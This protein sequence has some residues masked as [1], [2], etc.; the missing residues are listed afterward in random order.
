MDSVAEGWVPRQSL[1]RGACPD[2]VERPPEGLGQELDTSGSLLCPIK[3]SDGEALSDAN[4]E[5][6][7]CD[8]VTTAAET[9]GLE[10]VWIQN[11]WSG[12]YH[13]AVLVDPSCGIQHLGRWLGK[14][15]KP[16]ASLGPHYAVQC[17]DPLL[18]G[19]NLCRHA[20]CS[21]CAEM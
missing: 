10:T 2:I 13:R 17:E 12:T 18:L 11:Q 6:K 16:R 3:E 15:C 21:P 19:F 9:S 14:A 8:T 20:A 7:D 5:A 1:R 4:S